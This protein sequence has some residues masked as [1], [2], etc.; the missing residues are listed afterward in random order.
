ML[1]KEA[2][3]VAEMIKAATTSLM[4]SSFSKETEARSTKTDLATLDEQDRR[5]KV[6][7][8]NTDK[9]DKRETGESFRA[10]VESFFRSILGSC[11]G[12]LEVASFFVKNTWKPA[13][14]STTKGRT[15]VSKPEDINV[16]SMGRHFWVSDDRRRRSLF[17][18]THVNNKGFQQSQELPPP[19]TVGEDGEHCLDISHNFDD[20]I[21]ALSAHTLEE[22]ALQNHSFRGEPMQMMPPPITPASSSSGSS[23]EEDPNLL[24]QHFSQLDHNSPLSNAYIIHKG[25][26][27][28]K[29]NISEDAMAE[30]GDVTFLPPRIPKRRYVEV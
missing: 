14:E 29:F 26:H 27:D 18:V 5:K 9:G 7:P 15:G 28:S 25:K 11:G 4:P 19:F 8:T 6:A 1:K 2:E 3:E 12:V 23:K 13:D 20:N 30:F 17:Q 22:M 10:T 16:H 24:P 21:S